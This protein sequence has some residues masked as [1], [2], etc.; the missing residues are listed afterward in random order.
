METQERVNTWLGGNSEYAE[1][2]GVEENI[3]I[4]ADGSIQL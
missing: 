3:E 4:L 2:H 1:E